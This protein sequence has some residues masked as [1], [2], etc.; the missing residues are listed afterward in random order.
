MTTV[1]SGDRLLP[2]TRGRRPPPRRWLVRVGAGL[3]VLLALLP[4]VLGWVFADAVLAPEGQAD[5]PLDGSVLATE[6]GSVVLPDE[7]DV[8]LAVVGLETADGYWQL[9]GGAREV[10]CPG[11]SG[12]CVER[13]ATPVTGAGSSPAA[14]PARLDAAAWPDDPAVLGGSK[15]VL[16]GGLPAWVFPAR[17]PASG[18]W[19]VYAHGRSASL[20][21]SMRF[22]DLLTAAGYPVLVTSHRGDGL[23]ADPADGVGGFGTREWPDLDTA[24]ASALDRGAEDVVLWGTSQGAA[25]VARQLEAGEHADVVRAVVYDSPLLSLERTLE[26]QAAKRGLPT[27]LLRSTSVDAALWWAGV[28]A[29]FD[30]DAAEH[31]ERAGDWSRPTLVLHGAEDDQVPVSISRRIADVADPQLVQVEV[32]PGVGH[33]R[34]WNADPD[35]YAETVTTFLAQALGRG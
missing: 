22:V 17:A 10:D 30:A 9:T 4:L 24:V 28:R 8:R 23:A 11:G 25:L 14:G 15:V 33:V 1:A 2:D 27:D 32:L 3:V 26:L 7:P 18:T 31:A 5:R 34:G 35:G 12:T 20:A 29:D 21:E 16:D 6:D 19:V 13:R